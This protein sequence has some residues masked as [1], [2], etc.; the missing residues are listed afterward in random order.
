MSVN[1]NIVFDLDGTLSNG[2]HRL[3]YIEKREKDWV[4]YFA[5]CEKDEPILPITTLFQSMVDTIAYKRGITAPYSTISIWSGRSSECFMKTLAWLREHLRLRANGSPYADEELGM[6]RTVLYAYGSED[7]V[8]GG[9]A[10][11]IDFRMRLEGNYTDDV[12]LKHRWLHSI[13]S[14]QN[15]P[16]LVFEDRTRVVEMWRRAGIQCCQVTDGDF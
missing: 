9:D 8:F 16:N 7:Y 6:Y 12:I 11:P 2:E 15:R 3:H 14:A 13:H 4:K 10:V 5:E 1:L